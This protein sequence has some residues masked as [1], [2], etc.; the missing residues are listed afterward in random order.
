MKIKISFK[1]DSEEYG[2]TEKMIER[3]TLGEE[4]LDFLANALIDVIPHECFPPFNVL[5]LYTNGEMRGHS[6]K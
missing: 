1:L 2:I 5:E 6:E 3:E 4:T